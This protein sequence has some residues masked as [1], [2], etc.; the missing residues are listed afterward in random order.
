[1]EKVTEPGR[2]ISLAE[3]YRFERCRKKET[4]NVLW[5][6]FGLTTYRLWSGRQ[7]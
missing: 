4:G 3:Q 2:K 7:E 1:M 5:G 6:C